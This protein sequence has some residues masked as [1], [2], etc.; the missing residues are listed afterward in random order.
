M[1]TL[2]ERPR[3]IRMAS[4]L[5]RHF[6]EKL[7]AEIGPYDLKRMLRTRRESIAVLDVRD[8]EQY[9][10][11]HLP[12]AVNIPLDQLENRIGEVTR[13]H[14]VICYCGSITCLSSARAAYLLASKGILARELIG[15]FKAWQ[16]LGFPLEK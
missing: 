13:F 11:W 10:E 14:E 5:K 6:Q 7:A 4:A 1:A 9:Q 8:R 15:G 12:G 2:I 3:S 16:E